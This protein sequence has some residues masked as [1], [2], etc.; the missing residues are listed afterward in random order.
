VAVVPTL[1]HNGLFFG[2][3]SGAI[4]R[5]SAWSRKEVLRGSWG[6]FLALMDGVTSDALKTPTAWRGTG[7]TARNGCCNTVWIYNKKALHQLCAV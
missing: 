4:T 2:S 1:P 6:E 5:G 3:A 7:R